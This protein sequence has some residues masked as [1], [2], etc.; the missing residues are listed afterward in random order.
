ML[1]GEVLIVLRWFHFLAGITWIGLLYWFNF[2]N[3]PF[4]RTLD[5]RTRPIIIP[6]LVGRAVFWFR[7]A[8]WVTVLLGFVL[9]YGLYWQTGRIDFVN[10]N[11]F[12][13][14]FSGMLLGVV[15][16]FNVWVIIW[17]AQRQVIAALRAGEVPDPTWM[18]NTS[19][20]AR[21]NVALSFPL[22][23]FMGAASHFPL[24][25]P[26]IALVAVAAGVLG[27]GTVLYVQ[28]W[29]IARF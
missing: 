8:A 28:K 13:T 5:A 16:L 14:I 4:A 9:I 11:G 3:V 1:S 27:L 19:Y 29:A 22:L 17:P 12:K 25:W 7:H 15:M 6:A 21:A 18:R 23:F 26:Q 24:D 10:D 2:V 20:A